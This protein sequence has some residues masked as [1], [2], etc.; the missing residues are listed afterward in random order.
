M[1][2]WGQTGAVYLEKKA[3]RR[4]L[5]GKTVLATNRLTTNLPRPMTTPMSTRSRIDLI[6]S[7]LAV[8]RPDRLVYLP[9]AKHFGL[10]LAL[11]L[12]LFFLA[13]MAYPKGPSAATSKEKAVREA[14][15]RARADALRRGVPFV[16]PAMPS[17]R[18]AGTPAHLRPFHYAL[19]AVLALG[20]CVAALCPLRHRVEFRVHSGDHVLRVKDRGPAR[21]RVFEEP[22]SPSTQVILRPR[23]H[24]DGPGDSLL[25]QGRGLCWT[26]EL[27]A[28]A[29][30]PPVDVEIEYL[31]HVT[32]KPPKK[33]CHL[34]RRIAEMTGWPLN[35]VDTRT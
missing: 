15:E 16:C 28:T 24:H 34:A 23:E 10:Y 3:Y 17:L 22:L 8:D 35:E 33:A 2:K 4:R 26:V 5:A 21:S 18:K 20:A 31:S 13:A 6:H 9:G 12:A 30:L 7:W 14:I 32:G 1:A 11:A 19:A 27:L 29:A 25:S